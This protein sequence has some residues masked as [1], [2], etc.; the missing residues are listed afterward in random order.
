MSE[1]LSSW[2]VPCSALHGDMLQDQRL[3]HTMKRFKK[4]E[5]LL[6]VYRMLRLE[7]LM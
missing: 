2:G 5:I 4:K 1:E 6:L 7:V 3:P